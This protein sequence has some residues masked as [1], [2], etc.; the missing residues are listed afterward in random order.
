M[1][2]SH[3]D[4]MTQEAMGLIGPIVIH[5]RRPSRD[6]EVDRDFVL[7]CVPRQL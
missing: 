4:A 7:M 2:H 3:H 5:P 6:Y 1:Y